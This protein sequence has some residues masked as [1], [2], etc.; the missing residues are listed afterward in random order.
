MGYLRLKGLGVSPGI[1]IGEVFLSEKPFFSEVKERISSSQIKKEIQ[2]FRE[3][4]K[5]TEKQLHDIKNK[6][7][8]KL[9]EEYSFIFEAHLLI[10]KDESL[11]KEIEKI[12][13]E[14]EVK[15]E[16]ALFVIN[17]KYAKIFQSIE[18]DYFKQRVSD[19]KDVLIRI[20]KNL[21][22]KD[23]PSQLSREK[24]ILICHE[25]APSDAATILSREN[26][27]GIALDMGGQTSHTAILARSLNIPAVVGLRNIVN[28]VKDGDKMILDGTTGEIIINPPIAVIKEF[29]SKK[30]RYE[31]Y[32]KELTKIKFLEPITLDGVSFSLQG[33]IELPE[34][35]EIALSYGGE[36][37]GLFRSEYLYLHYPDPPTEEKH[38]SAYYKVA[39]KAYPYSVVI[40]TVDVGGEKDIPHL[41]IEKEPNPALGLR[42][43]RL[44]LKKKELFKIQLR[45]ILRASALKN[46]KILLPMITQIEEIKEFKSLLEEAKEELREKKKD[47]DPEIP[48]GVM[49]EVPA[50][51]NIADLL[52]KEVDFLSIGTND[53]IQYYLAVD[54]TNEFVSYLYQPF[55]PSIL[56]VLRFVIDVCNK[57][58][59]EV[60]VC[61]EM[62]AD[63]LSALVLLG[64]GLKNFSMNPVFIPKVKK[65]LRE[66]EFK[67]IKKIVEKALKLETAQ[68]V[69]EYVLERILSK[70]PQV[71]L[72]KPEL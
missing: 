4:L 38:Y 23:K 17:N 46:I 66:V 51:A 33:N 60:T 65:A 35:V 6:I 40:R 44:F 9:G 28:Y 8:K 64:L 48:V 14:E 59:R 68:E 16:W 45:A 39:K 55:H 72:K 50:A 18:D 34:E 69:E 37:I 30:Q 20:N 57:E 3:A 21:K 10:L 31:D 52:V 43:I 41:E 36:G 5:K 54:R 61:G 2:R 63:P 19:I 42:A 56:R 13:K 67:E 70:Y 26:I 7:K 71:F 49:I 22:E 53:L 62:A 12:I 32:Q 25:L 29:L 58:K 15:T 24:K 1:A 27:L 11:I 47:F